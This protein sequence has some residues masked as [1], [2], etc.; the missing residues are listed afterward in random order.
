[1]DGQ[2]VSQAFFTARLGLASLA[3]VAFSSME[4]FAQATAH[5]SWETGCSE[6]LILPIRE[7]LGTW[8]VGA[9]PVHS[10]P[11]PDVPTTLGPATSTSP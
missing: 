4:I 6:V 1:M 10:L 8:K 3:G 5:F 9:M 11:W 2:F 7:M